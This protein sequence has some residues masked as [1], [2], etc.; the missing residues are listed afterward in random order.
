MDVLSFRKEHLHQV[1]FNAGLHRDVGDRHNRTKFCQH[2]WH[3]AGFYDLHGNG[4]GAIAVRC[5]VVTRMPARFC[6]V[7]RPQKG[8]G[9]HTNACERDAA[10]DKTFFPVGCA[11]GRG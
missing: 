10:P 4:L 8:K 11:G 5:G 6:G 9:Q 7:M 1:A 3:G 2:N